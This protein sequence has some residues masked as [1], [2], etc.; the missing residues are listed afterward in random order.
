[1][2]ENPYTPPVAV[3]ETA[4]ER[5]EISIDG[6]F[7]VVRSGAVLPSRCVVTNKKTNGNA[8][9]FWRVFEWAP[10][11]RPVLRRGKC[12]VSYCVHS[13]R[14]WAHYRNRFVLS[15]LLLVACWIPFGNGVWW[16]A[17]LI[18]V[19]MFGTAVDPLRVRTMKDGYFWI[20]GCGL[21]FLREC[22]NE[23]SGQLE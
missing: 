4:V 1:M 14:R 17:I 22:E 23:I 13:D 18:P 21:E 20:E 10:T 15:L 2:N 9:R 6:S 11:F 12:R 19:V 7:L 8:D 5:P 16:F 3:E